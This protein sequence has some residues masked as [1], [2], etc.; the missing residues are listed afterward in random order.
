M[1]LKEGGTQTLITTSNVVVKLT[2]KHYVD[3]TTANAVE[4]DVLLINTIG[5]AP[6]TNCNFAFSRIPRFHG[7]RGGADRD[8]RGI[9]RSRNHNDRRLR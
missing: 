8:V 1:S 6:K 4:Y 3:Y 7:R 5:V 9:V 2:H